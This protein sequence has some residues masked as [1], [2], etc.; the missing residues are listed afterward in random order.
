M[1]ILQLVLAFD[2]EKSVE[3]FAKM[4][5]LKILLFQNLLWIV[6]STYSGDNSI[7]KSMIPMI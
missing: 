3:N 5:L 2:V 7:L 6:R 4:L 1:K